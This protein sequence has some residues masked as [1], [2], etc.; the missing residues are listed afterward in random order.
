MARFPTNTLILTNISDAL[1]DDPSPLM[2]FLANS[3][4]V[5][6]LISLKRFGRI[7]LICDNIHDSQNIKRLLESND[8]WSDFLVSF[9]I[10]DN[11][12]SNKYGVETQMDYLELPAEN[13]NKRFL[14]SPP[15]SP[16]PE[17]DHWDKVEEG[18]NKQ[19]FYKP[20]EL[21]HLLWER[22]GGVDSNEVRK[23]ESEKKRDLS[24]E[25]QVLFEDIDN[26]VPAIVLDNV[27]S[28]P[29]KTGN[30][31]IPHTSLPPL[32]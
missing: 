17:W 22:L 12:V 19:T 9:S 30:Q 2:Q 14:I 25:P 15:L 7:L 21:S 23:Y 5:C 18:P 8:P 3:Q 4:Q 26:N 24:I 28:E 32:K 31:F 20:E 1:L 6:E 27:D 13:G 10:Q 11:E 16:P 29:V